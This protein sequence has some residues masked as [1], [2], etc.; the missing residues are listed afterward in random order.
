MVSMG[1]PLKSVKMAAKVFLP[2]M[3]GN[4]LFIACQCHSFARA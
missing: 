1:T 4:M 3:K 2:I